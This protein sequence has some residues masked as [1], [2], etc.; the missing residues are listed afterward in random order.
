M[1]YVTFFLSGFTAHFL[2]YDVCEKLP[3][4]DLSKEAA[5]V[6]V[7][8]PLARWLY[9][10]SKDFDSSFLLPFLFV[11]IGVFVARVF[12]QSRHTY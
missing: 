3:M 4:A 5:G 6:L 10:K 1:R 9:H 7:T 12:R 2:L 11:G 8:Y